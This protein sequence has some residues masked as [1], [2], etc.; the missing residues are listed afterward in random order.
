MTGFPGILGAASKTPDE[1]L[2]WLNGEANPDHDFSGVM[3]EVAFDAL[4]TFISQEMVDLSGYVNSDK[5]VSGDPDSGR[6]LFN[7]ACA[8]C[9]GTDGK[10]FNFGTEDE[11]IYVGTLAIDNPWEVFH[12]T[13]HGQPGAPM[14]G[15]VA[16]EWTPDQIADVIA[17]TQTLPTE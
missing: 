11:P 15:A 4:V 7:N 14:P 1:L 16:L 17:Y 10:E 9:H 12:K 8:K 5:T 6:S 2:A 3:D 13:A